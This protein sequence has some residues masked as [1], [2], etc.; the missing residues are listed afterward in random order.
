MT[1]AYH[2]QKPSIEEE[3]AVPPENLS[4]TCL[5][6]IRTGSIHREAGRQWGVPHPIFSYRISL[7]KENGA[8]RPGW[9]ERPRAQYQE[10][11]LKRNVSLLYN[12]KL[13]EAHEECPAE[14]TTP[15]RHLMIQ[16]T[17][18]FRVLPH[19]KTG[20]LWRQT[21]LARCRRSTTFP[22]RTRNST[23]S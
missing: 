3:E 8:L 2:A 21:H 10:T 18:I 13:T 9:V 6:V 5:E 12:R 17:T 4:K 14:P 11:V 23:V 19:L 22:A 1:T 15:Y 20:T 7:L 16:M